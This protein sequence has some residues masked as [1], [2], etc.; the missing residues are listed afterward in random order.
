[1]FG[2]VIKLDK[3]DFID[4][5]SKMTKEEMNEIIKKNGKPPKPFALFQFKRLDKK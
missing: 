2:S 1:M 5:L 3:E 4:E